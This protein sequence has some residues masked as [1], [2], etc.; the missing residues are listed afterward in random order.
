MSIIRRSSTCT[1]PGLPTHPG[2]EIARAQQ[3]GFGAMVSFELVGGTRVGGAFSRR[4]SQC[5][6]LAE[7]LGGV[8]SLIAHPATMTHASM[9]AEARAAAGITRL[10]RAA[11]GGHRSRRT[12]SCAISTD[13]AR[14]GCRDLRFGATDVA[15]LGRP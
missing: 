2:H 10:A 8:E 6:T 7:S 15:R 13:G 3:S 14:R 9:D 4:A 11:V 12:I 5:F 1:I